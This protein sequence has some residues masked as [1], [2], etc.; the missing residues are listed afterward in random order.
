M[1]SAMQLTSI[2]PAF[3]YRPV[4]D[5]EGKANSP[6][7]LPIVDKCAACKLRGEGFFCSLSP[8]SIRD[9]DHIKHTTSYPEGAMVFV[10][11]QSA[12][13]VYVVCQGRAKLMTTSRDGKTLI[14][15]IAGPGE[16][17][18]LHSVINGK[19]YEV[20]V[21]TLQPSQLA[22]IHRDDFLTFLKTHGDACLR[23]AEHLSRDC[24]SAYDSIR[25]IGLSH[26]VAE[27]LARLLLQ[28]AADGRVADGAIR[29]KITLTHEE[30]AQ[31]I[32]T[33]RETVTRVLGELKKRKIAELKGATLVVRNKAALEGLAT[34]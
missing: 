9:L 17:L 21:E 16:I 31:L 26:S 24:H 14:L 23:T 4:T 10:E 28:W 20:T 18:G 29:T 34:V 30:I 33:S 15:K 3:S 13:G 27:K 22:F 25:S 1:A 19:Q 7:G 2:A 32:G 8:N 5:I 6:Y 12:R 11:G